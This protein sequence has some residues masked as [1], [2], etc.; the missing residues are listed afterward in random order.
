M[1]VSYLHKIRGDL[2]DSSDFLSGKAPPIALPSL[3]TQL[4]TKL[5]LTFLY[6]SSSFIK[7]CGRYELATAFWNKTLP[8]KHYLAQNAKFY[9]STVCLF[10]P[11]HHYVHCFTIVLLFM[12]NKSGCGF[13]GRT[14]SNLLPTTL[15]IVNNP[16]P[17][18]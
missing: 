7:D 11:V 1:S 5:I 16:L 6:H 15:I 3:R 4:Y 13:N 9:Q 8:T 10:M 14:G 18:H 2:I 12:K 17:D